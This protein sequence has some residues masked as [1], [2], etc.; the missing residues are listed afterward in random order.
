LNALQE[1]VGIFGK[2][3]VFSN[4]IVGL[5]ETDKT[6]CQGIDE[7]AEMGVLPVLRAVYPH[8]LRAGEMEMRRP[9][10]DRLLRLAHY[11]RGALDKNGLRGDCALTGCY[12]CTGC[13]LVPHRDI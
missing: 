12:L 4:I 10:A 5:G 2:N 11:L 3:R 13:D 1:A 6:L 9:S 8:P 7:L